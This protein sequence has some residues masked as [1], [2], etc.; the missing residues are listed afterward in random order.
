METAT[1]KQIVTLVGFDQLVAKLSQK[2]FACLKR[3]VDI[4]NEI[5]ISRVMWNLTM[6]VVY[7]RNKNKYIFICKRMY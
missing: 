4:G 6:V 5:V 1:F 7:M 3:Y 2:M